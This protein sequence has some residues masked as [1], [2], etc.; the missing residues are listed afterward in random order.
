[1]SGNNFEWSDDV[2]QSLRQLWADGHSTAEIGRRIG[3]SKNA[4]VGKA[5]RLDLPRRPSPIAHDNEQPR[6]PSKITTVPQSQNIVPVEVPAPP[7]P[8]RPTPL[9]VCAPVA[10]N[11]ITP[12]PAVN[13]VSPQPEDVPRS[14]DRRAGR[15]CCW[16]IGEPGTKTF[17]FCDAAIEPRTPYCLDHARKAYAR[18]AEA[19]Q[20]A[21]TSAG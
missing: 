20:D 19:P 9:P 2:V 21:G 14:F 6:R 16:P 3:A 7:L 11:A 10:R 15:T 17:R 12:K 13:V 18:R 1:M 5:H 4:V 8:P